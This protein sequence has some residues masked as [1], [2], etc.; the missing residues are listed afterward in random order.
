MVKYDVEKVVC[1]RKKRK[2]K[3][4]FKRGGRGR[5]ERKSLS[6][7]SMTTSHLTIVMICSIQVSTFI[8]NFFILS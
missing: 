8:F 7:Q 3:K 1:L 6:C 2:K 5:K 4:N